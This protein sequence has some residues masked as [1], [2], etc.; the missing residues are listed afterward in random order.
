MKQTLHISRLLCLL[1]AVL[2]TILIATALLL[3]TSPAGRQSCGTIQDDVHVLDSA[4]V[5]AA[6]DQLSATVDIYTTKTFAGAKD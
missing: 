6:S 4:K 1:S 3:V 5:K 2:F